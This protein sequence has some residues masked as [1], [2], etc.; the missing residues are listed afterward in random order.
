MEVPPH[1]N[2]SSGALSV[3]RHAV[4]GWEWK[5][6][7]KRGFKKVGWVSTVPDSKLLLKV[8]RAPLMLC[9]KLWCSAFEEPVCGRDGWIFQPVC[10]SYPVRR[11]MAIGDL[12]TAAH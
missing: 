7:G 9:C 6:E 5:D 10:S 4:Q 8:R 11:G 1:V 12:A 3:V 2:S